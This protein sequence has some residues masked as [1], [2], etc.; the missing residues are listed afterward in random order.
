MAI[1]KIY[2]ITNED[3][4]LQDNEVMTQKE[5]EITDNLLIKVV[6]LFIALKNIAKTQNRILIFVKLNLVVF[7]LISI[8]MKNSLII[9]IK[10]LLNIIMKL[11]K[12][13]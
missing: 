13:I 11:R 7:I 10:V 1:I 8:F 9:L 12:S 3:R 4:V 5:A 6:K 2:V